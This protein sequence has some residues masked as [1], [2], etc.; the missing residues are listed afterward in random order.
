[1][2]GVGA[3]QVKRVKRFGCFSKPAHLVRVLLF[4]SSYDGY[5]LNLRN[6]LS[7]C[8]DWPGTKKQYLHHKAQRTMLHGST[9][10]AL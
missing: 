1:M 7:L 3:S 6:G 10:M 4:G 5:V 9:C 2:L 8:C